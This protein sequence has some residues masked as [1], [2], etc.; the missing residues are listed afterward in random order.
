MKKNWSCRKF[1]HALFILL[2][3]FTSQHCSSCCP[4]LLFTLYPVCIFFSPF[5]PCNSLPILFLFDNFIYTEHLYKPQSVQTSLH[6]TSAIQRTGCSF[7]ST[8]FSEIFLS[9]S[10]I[11]SVAKHTSEDD[12]SEDGWLDLILLEEEGC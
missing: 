8:S 11:F 5:Y 4:F 12:N 7:P 3:L 10:L 9:F 2:T 1:L 6:F